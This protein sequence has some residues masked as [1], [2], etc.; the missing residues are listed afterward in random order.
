VATR[1]F[2]DSEG[3]LA[4]PANPGLGLELDHEAVKFYTDGEDLFSL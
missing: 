2:L 1:W 4:I 3:C